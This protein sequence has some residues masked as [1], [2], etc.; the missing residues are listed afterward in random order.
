MHNISPP[1]SQ[2]ALASWELE[3]LVKVGF[4]VTLTFV[5]A[6]VHFQ[7]P[8]FQLRHV[9]IMQVVTETTSAR[10]LHAYLMRTSFN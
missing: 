2:F 6:S 9:A 3:L 1:A 8:P 10:P 7:I 5:T 4:L